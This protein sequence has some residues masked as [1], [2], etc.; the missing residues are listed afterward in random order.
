MQP[1]NNYIKIVGEVYSETIDSALLCLKWNDK[2]DENMSS[3]FHGSGMVDK[4]RRTKS[5]G[6]GTETLGIQP[7]YK[8][9]DRSDQIV[10]YYGYGHR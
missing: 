6:G 10:L 3:T 8:G 1:S 5:A 9:V 4:K 2:R 7:A